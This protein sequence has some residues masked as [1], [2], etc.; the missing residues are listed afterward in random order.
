MNFFHHKDPGNHLLQL[1][2]KVVK[3]SVC[4]LYRFLGALEILAHQSAVNEQYT[5]SSLRY[6]KR[7]IIIIII[8]ITSSLL[9][10]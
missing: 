6:I 8:I 3:H 9:F 1:C 5:D 4:G 2:P 10:S 7:T